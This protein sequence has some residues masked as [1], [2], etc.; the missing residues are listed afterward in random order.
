MDKINME[1]IV[2]HSINYSLDELKNLVNSTPNN[3]FI[4]KIRRFMYKIKCDNDL[5]GEIFR[6]YPK[7]INHATLEFREYLNS[8]DG[9]HNFSPI[10][11][12]NYG[13]IRC[14]NIYHQYEDKPGWLYVHITHKV[15]YPVYR[16]VAETWLECPFEDSLNWQ[17]HHISN[18]GYDN[19][20]SNLVWIKND[21]H[22]SIPTRRNIFFAK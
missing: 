11:V 5:P 22:K 1:N 17:V 19:S 14:Q 15:K 12:S 18:D 16:L 6:K 2:S 20:P 9:V 7:N 10:E 8:F 4:H 21:F 13:R 3:M